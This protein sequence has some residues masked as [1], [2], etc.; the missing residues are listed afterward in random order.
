MRS[1]L[2]Y[3]LL[4]FVSAAALPGVA[5]AQSA[6]PGSNPPASPSAD[7]P[8]APPSADQTATSP[9]P[10]SDKNGGLEDIVVT[11]NRRNE[12]LQ[13][14]P[15][16]I[17]SITA[18][19]LAQAGVASTIDIGSKV[20]GFTVQQ[21]GNG[22]QPHIRGVGT[23]DVVAGNES[24]VATYVDGIYI[25]AMSGAMLGLNNI[26]QVDVLKGPQGTLFGRNA[27]G[28]VVNVR[29]K[30]PTQK[31]GLDV[32]ATYGNFNTAS[33]SLYV[34]GGLSNNLAA[35]FAAYGLYQA[36]G[37]GKNLFNGRDVGRTR[38][39]SL[40]TK[41]L[42]TPTDT[43]TVRVA[44]DKSHI[45]NDA[46]SAYSPVPGT[47]LNDPD[48]PVGTP[49]IL[50]AK[51][52]NQWDIDHP[53]Q[54]YWR[55]GQQ[56]VSLT[57]ELE[58]GF[59]KITTIT[60]LRS[61]EKN[62]GWEL[63]E[64]PLP[65]SREFAGWKERSHQF[66]QELQIAS[67][68]GSKI[69]WVAGAFYLHSNTGYDPF[70]LLGPDLGLGP[71]G[72]IQWT[73]FAKTDAGALY[74]QTTIP[75]FTDTHLT[76]GFRYSIERKAVSGVM[77]FSPASLGIPDIITDAH[78]VFKK[79]TWRISLDHQFTPDLLGYVSYNRGFKSGIYNTIPPGG[80][81]AQPV[82]PETIDAY[83]AGFKSELFDHRVRLNVA[84]F[85]YDYKNIQVDI[86]TAAA[87]IIE[88]AKAARIYGVDF[89]LTAKP[90]DRFTLDV[91][92]AYVH[93]RFTDFPHG[94]ISTELPVALGGGRTVAFDQNLNGRRIPYTPDWTVNVGATYEIPVR[95][96]KVVLNGNYSYQSVIYAGPDN[97]YGQPGYSNINAQVSWKLDS[98]IEIGL[99]GKNLTNNAHATF[100]ANQNNP[101]GFTDRILAPPRTYGVTVR[102][103]M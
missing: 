33:G 102:F 70:F 63:P 25:S 9:A 78:K 7:Q 17:Q 60:A 87:A 81:G 74:A 93:D 73:A 66:S 96:G 77:S 18:T 83:E 34:T 12:N 49:G 99:W 71:D 23:T 37:F 40:R 39:Y 5:I 64:R 53:A 76:A 19:S 97:T 1:K 48:A 68:P 52:N 65:A 94:S 85:L 62:L 44:A 28:G 100:V 95:D 61:S 16:S 46:Y 82:E 86:Y 88:S 69:S 35:D 84:G 56:G 3:T 80:P 72:G 55:F 67:L 51:P 27:T 15:I 42:W 59:A 101:G 91:S 75:I 103:H 98:G 32:S 92:G 90:T 45:D 54:P 11:A 31:L 14:V 36:D 43:L 24:A 10:A 57:A 29:T 58:T 38:E 89:E 20:A 13:K 22:L 47:S 6:P 2:R 21:S 4:A 8:T 79:P 30:D 26:A 50:V 41:W